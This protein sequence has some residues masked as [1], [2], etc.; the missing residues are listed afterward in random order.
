MYVSP[1]HPN[2]P[3]QAEPPVDDGQELA[4]IQRPDGHELRLRLK[5]YNDR[6]Y[7]SA[8]LWSRNPDGTAWPVK[9]RSVSF[10]MG[11]LAGVIDALQAAIGAGG[12][13]Q[14]QQDRRHQVEA[15][16]RGY[17][18][19]EAAPHQAPPVDPTR[20]VDKGRPS[21]PPFD[22]ARGPR[23]TGGGGFSEFQ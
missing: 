8:Q 16:P 1:H 19:A 21:R 3:R 2:P 20:Y 7:V 4:T 17:L 18:P 12:E 10:R 9:G 5:A 15:V 11:E 22:A 23:Q 6:P 13:H 14:R